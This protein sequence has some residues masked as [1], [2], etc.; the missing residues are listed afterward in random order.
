MNPPSAFS[1]R[2]IAVA[3]F[4]PSLLF[5]LG[6]GAI[7]PVIALSARD[8]GASVP[9]AALLVMLIGAGAMISNIPASMLTM[10]R[11][12][13]WAIV[14]AALW[15]AAAM[16]MSA[17]TSHLWLFAIGCLMVGMAQG[18]FGLARQ[19]YLTEAVPV[20]YRARALS[21]LG[22][23][24]R[25]GM[26]VG[27]FIGA[28]AIVR[29]GLAGA[30]GVGVVA[31][32]LAAVVAARLPDLQVE[33]HEAAGGAAPGTA[34]PA[35][36]WLG[37]LRDH[38][39]VLLTLGFG[40]ALVAA[41]RSSRQAI[42]PLWADHLALE[43]SVASLIFGVAAGIE[44]LLFY[45]AGRVMDR[46]GRTWVAVPSMVLMGVALLLTPL[47]SGATTLLVAACLIGIGNGIS[48]G[49]I[50]TIGADHSPRVGRAHF[51]GVWRLLTD[52]GAAC[53]PAL[54]S[55]VAA[56]L[57][58]GAAIAV[59]GLMALAGAVQLGYWLPRASP[60]RPHGKPGD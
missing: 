38:R 23:V 8:L 12:E 43:P 19:S 20:E 6:E 37:T 32:L 2:R 54:L 49:L 53:G 55:A 26:F 18:V 10:H 59:T 4:G 28:A 30:Y 7:L 34:A 3:A 11:G 21:T 39:H 27:P 51:L 52:I 9:T 41:V 17:W 60:G 29:F 31:L 45:P 44:M 56:A 16:A 48:S 5:G 35:P 36:T 1:L 42:I 22:G 50:M 13:R 14:A 46:K 40:V 15:C 33:G 25:I 57:S 47:A 24:M 58:L